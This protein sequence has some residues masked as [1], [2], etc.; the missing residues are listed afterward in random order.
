MPNYSSG[1]RMAAVRQVQ[2]RET[3]ATSRWAAIVAVATEI[4]CSPTTLRRWVRV[5]EQHKPRRPAAP[6]RSTSN[7]AIHARPNRGALAA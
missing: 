1:D 7:P 5:I 3:K 6:A 4:G 2:S